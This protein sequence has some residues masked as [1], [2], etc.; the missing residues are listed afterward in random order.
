[1][2]YS[3]NV[4]LLVGQSGTTGCLA[5]P[6]CPLPSTLRRP[7]IAVKIT[8]QERH[9]LCPHGDRRDKYHLFPSCERLDYSSSF[10]YR[11]FDIETKRKTT[12]DY[13]IPIPSSRDG[14]EKLPSL[15]IF[16]DE[17]PPPPHPFL[18][19]FYLIIFHEIHILF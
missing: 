11:T 16:D 3:L 18:G 8:T 14:N 10:S 9:S 12:A 15:I 2:L 4:L 1:M 17:S 6:H 13:C 5:L 19:F 7:M